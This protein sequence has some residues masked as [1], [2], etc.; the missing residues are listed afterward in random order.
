MEPPVARVLSKV[1]ITG[2]MVKSRAPHDE[3]TALDKC[4]RN[5]WL[6]AD[7]LN[8]TPS[9]EETIFALP[10]D[11]HRWFVEW[12]LFKIA[13]TPLKL[14]GILELAIKV[15]SGFSPTLLSTERRIG[16]GCIQ[17]PPEAQ[18]QDEF[19]RSCH[20]YSKGQL[21]TFPE[22][23]TTKG[24]VDFYIPSKEWGVGLVCDGDRLE[25]HSGR[26][27]QSGSYGANLQLSDHIILDFRKT[28]PKR[29]HPGMCIIC[30]SIHSPFFELTLHTD[31]PKLYHIVFS[32]YYHE[33]VILD[34]RLQ[35]VRGGEFRLLNS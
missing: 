22:Y 2:S 5:G 33:V 11:L 32:E 8:D 27:S 10:S 16:P 19:Y 29:P 31:I 4:Y 30:P 7:K 17:R 6:H 23:G 13:T 21:I 15:I 18:Y 26:F 1:L 3:V 20:T 12:K 9:S 24:W 34:H 28:R 14:D 25:E 35:P